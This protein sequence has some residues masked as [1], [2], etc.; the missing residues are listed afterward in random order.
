MNKILTWNLQHGGGN[1][2]DRIVDVLK[3]H[4]NPT[5]LV[6]TEFRN[7]NNGAIIQRV[8]IEMGFIYQFKTDADT[9]KNAVLIASKEDYDFLTF[10]ELNEHAHRVI[11]VF[12]SELS[13]Y[14][15]YFP[16][17]EFK[18]PVFEFCFQK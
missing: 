12:N 6:L 17:S 5:T 9:N 18:K 8:L 1:R 7:N 3:Q 10:P 11:K 4:Q 15:C 14:G 16:Q 13:I 2:I